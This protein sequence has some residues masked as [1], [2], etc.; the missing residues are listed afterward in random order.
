MLPFEATKLVSAPAAEVW[1]RLATPGC[2]QDLLDGYT[3]KKGRHAV[4]MDGSGSPALGPGSQGSVAAGRWRLSLRVLTFSPPR[5]LTLVCTDVSAPSL[6]RSQFQISISLEEVDDDRTSANAV[7]RLLFHWWP[8]Q[9]LSMLIPLG[10]YHRRHL[11][12]A[13]DALTPR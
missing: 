3:G 8:M 10:W 9:L 1:S 7:C 2:W 6:F 5:Q 11:A 13:L 12:R 4:V